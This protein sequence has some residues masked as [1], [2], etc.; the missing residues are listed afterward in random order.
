MGINKAK[1]PRKKRKNCQLG[2]G[3]LIL[4]S[5]L[6]LLAAVPPPEDKVVFLDV[7]QGDA[8]LLQEGTRQVLIDG[9]PGMAV[10]RRL[11]KEMPWFDRRL[12]VVVLTHPQR[13]HLEGLLHALDR[14]EVNLVLLPR[15]AHASR[16]QEVWL[17]KISSKGIPY[18]FAWAGQE[19]RAG[20]IS[21]RIL[22]PLDTEAA[23]AA[24]RADVNNASVAVRADFHGLSFLLTGDNEKRLE[25]VL[26]RNT[27]EKLLDVD[28][29]K[30]GHHGSKTSTTQLLVDRA[31]PSATVISVGADNKFGHPSLEV[32]ERLAGRPLWRTDWSGSIRFIHTKS[33]QWLATTLRQ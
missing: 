23:R 4:I 27:E 7:G 18:R 2:G 11:G 5:T 25:V 31:S 28:V 10:L 1:M 9:G 6:L 30:A 16:M 3:I 15:V 24:A 20:D 29:L 21:L 32:L 12:E 8:I 17:E 33:E 19:L 14:Y 13:D 22:A 26:V